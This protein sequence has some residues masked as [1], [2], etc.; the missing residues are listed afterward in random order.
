MS[1]KPDRNGNIKGFIKQEHHEKT[2]INLEKK[3]FFLQDKLDDLNNSYSKLTNNHETIK[4]EYKKKCIDYNKLLV[5]LEHKNIKKELY[6][7]L[8][9]LKTKYKLYFEKY[10]SLDI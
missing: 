7:E 6:E 3:I 4:N 5:R 9:D 1:L 10:G 2:K 8:Q